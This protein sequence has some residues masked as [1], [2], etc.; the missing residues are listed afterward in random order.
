M[1]TVEKY[2][3]DKGGEKLPLP[4]E[5]CYGTFAAVAIGEK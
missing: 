4:I 5:P 3:V 2:T 1:F